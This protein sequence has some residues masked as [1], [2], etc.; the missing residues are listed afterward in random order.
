MWRAEQHVEPRRVDPAFVADAPIGGR[1]ED[2]LGRATFARTLADVLGGWS[3]GHSLVIGLRGG[4]GTGKSSI[5]NMALE[6]LRE[7]NDPKPFVVEFTPWRWQTSEQITTAFFHEVFVAIGKADQ[8]PAGRKRAQRWLRYA[9]LVSGSAETMERIG[10]NLPTYAATIAAATMFGFSLG[11]AVEWLETTVITVGTIIIVLA[12]L[13]KVFR[14]G[15]RL[16]EIWLARHVERE[17]TVEEARQELTEALRSLQRNIVVVID[18]IDRLREPEIRLVFQHVKVNGDFPNLV[19]L[20]VFQRAVVEGSLRT[21]VINGR[22]YLE[23]IVQVFLDVPQV[24]HHRLENILVD[25]LNRI[26]G[27]YADPRHGFDEP[28][29]GNLL[30]FG[31]RPYLRHLRDVHRLAGSL[32]VQTA[33]FKGTRTLEVNAVDLIGLEAL[34]VF[35]PD[36]YSALPAS[37]RMLVASGRMHERDAEV[38]Q[39]IEGILAKGNQERRSALEHIMRELFPSIDWVFPGG[40][41]RDGEGWS[42]E[43]RVCSE[44]HFDRYFVLAIPEGQISSSEMDELIE[45]TAD[46]HRF[47]TVLGALEERGLLLEAIS[48]LDGAQDAISLGAAGEFLPA[49]M[50]FAERLNAE[51]SGTLISPFMH[52]RR[53]VRFY[54]LRLDDVE[55][56][57]DLFLNAFTASSGLSLAASIL[58]SEHSRR[59]KGSPDSLV[60][61]DAGLDAAKTAWVDRIADQAMDPDALLG[62][63]HIGML[64]HRW[65]D[66]GPAGAA[67][68]WVKRVASTDDGLA[69]IVTAL[70]NRGWAHTIGD[71]T[72]HRIWHARLPNIERFVAVEAWE[73]RLERLLASDLPAEQRGAIKALRDAIARR[74]TG[75]NEPEDLELE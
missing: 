43:K 21:P 53:V 72:A 64:L 20:L 50:N 40:M 41:E 37:K 1:A 7:G 66:W 61:T 54:L 17:V 13:A 62:H 9:R 11:G 4:W 33:L 56:R 36:V 75:E 63:P 26:L 57:T 45:A 10:E 38:Q 35:E 16:A 65:R 68:E 3:G 47:E 70:V 15:G 23:K 31:L 24:E 34:R 55:Q 74:R 51:G 30:V 67:S 44:R 6:A 58:L 29:W 19:Y 14:F 49:M 27:P 71:A 5:K 22:E 60:F 28:R 12:V 32:S 39:A 8:S 52:A 46:R 18:D 25:S 59:E 2:V 73:P 69:R 42:I 48:M